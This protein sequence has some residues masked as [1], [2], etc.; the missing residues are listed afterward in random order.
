MNVLSDFIIRVDECVAHQ[1]KK[2]K[3]AP[4]A[5]VNEEPEESNEDT[6]EKKRFYFKDLEKL[7]KAKLKNVLAK[8]DAEDLVK[9]LYDSSE[10][11]KDKLLSNVNRKTLEEFE[12]L[13]EQIKEVS[14]KEIKNAQRRILNHWKKIK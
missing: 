1:P 6:S 13:S 14:K 5:K 11:L 3:P 4:Q 8:F 10:S 9:A 12:Q 2:E 7:S